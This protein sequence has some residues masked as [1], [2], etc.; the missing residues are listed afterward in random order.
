MK[1]VRLSIV[2]LIVVMATVELRAQS[3]GY[4][5]LFN[6]GNSEITNADLQ[7]YGGLTHQHQNFF[8]KAFSF[9]GIEAG[10]ILH[11]SLFLGFYGSAF[12]SNLK[13]EIA[14]NPM[15]IIINQAGF[16]G[17]F[18]RNGSRLFHPGVLLNIGYFSLGGDDSAM[19]LFK[20]ADHEITFS[21]LVFSPQM[22]GEINVTKWMRFRTGLAYNFYSFGKNVSI[23]DSDLENF[24]INFGFLFGKF[25]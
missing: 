8:N 21:G 13:V 18:K 23:A 4:N 10:I 14:N 3:K 5:C 11:N 2:L 25:N 6:K 1:N 9:Q 15:Y 12:V 16:E 7:F 19:P 17:G 22:F 20:I 24:S